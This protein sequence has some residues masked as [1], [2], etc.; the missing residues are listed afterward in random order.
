MDHSSVERVGVD[1]FDIVRVGQN[2]AD[3]TEVMTLLIELHEENGFAPLDLDKASRNVYRTIGEGMTWLARAGEDLPIGVLGLTEHAFWY[4]NLTFLL[5]AWFYVRPEHRFG[6]VGVALMRRA[7]EEADR[8]GLICFIE[9][10]NPRKAAKGGLAS[11]AMERAGYI[12][13]GYM[14]RLMGEQH[15]RI[16]RDIDDHHGQQHLAQRDTQ[17]ADR[18][19]PKRRKPRPDLS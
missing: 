12:P 15:V 11:V 2:E 17:V 14:L 4:G 1:S 16:A 3:F 9:T 8:R 13:A 19:K 18:R 7:R 5:S 6:R 10:S